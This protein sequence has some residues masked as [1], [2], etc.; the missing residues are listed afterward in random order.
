MDGLVAKNAFRFI[1]KTKE[2]IDCRGD[3]IDDGIIRVSFRFERK[4]EER[5]VYHENHVTRHHYHDYYPYWDYPW[6]S[7]PAIW[8]SCGTFTQSNAVGSTTTSTVNYCASLLNNLPLPDEGITV[9]GS[10]VNQ[11]FVN[12][13][14]NE[15]E[16]NTKVITI[17][18][19]GMMTSGVEVK[20]PI[21]IKTRFKCET[22]GRESQSS[23]KFCVNCGTILI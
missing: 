6:Y 20:E 10:E 9:K 11:G 23:A 4:T 5:T 8:G 18:L 22:C 1:Q 17:R 16:S 13:Y 19:C 12:G 15:L 3:R 7:R 2:I 14:T 21:T